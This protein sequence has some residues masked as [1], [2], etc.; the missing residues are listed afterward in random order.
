MERCEP[1]Y[2]FLLCQNI[3][4][5]AELAKTLHEYLPWAIRWFKVVKFRGKNPLLQNNI[6]TMNMIFEI[7]VQNKLTLSY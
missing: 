1:K 4:K 7:N 3:R 2:N 5:E 6:A